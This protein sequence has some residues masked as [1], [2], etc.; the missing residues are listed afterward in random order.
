M[1]SLERRQVIN[2]NDA[3]LR[4]LRHNIDNVFSRLKG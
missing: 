1:L 3:D 4:R 2:Q